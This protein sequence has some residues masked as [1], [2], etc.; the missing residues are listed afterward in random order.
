MAISK[1]LLA[2]AGA[3][4]NNT[5]GSVTVESDAEEI[6][7]LFV[8]E[9]IGATPAVTWKIQGTM[10]RG[11]DASDANAQW[12]DIP[13]LTEAAAAEAVAARTGPII[14]NTAQVEF[15][16]AANVRFFQRFRA[17][18]SGNTNVTYRV[19]MYGRDSE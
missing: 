16:A 19:E 5:H 13:Y 18:V 14:A 8:C 4:G 6:A 7:F 11:A 3:T 12:F 9:A 2:P 15:L 1:V 10:Q 17:V